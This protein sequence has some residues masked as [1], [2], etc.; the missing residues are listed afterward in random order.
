VTARLDLAACMAVFAAGIVFSQT[1]IFSILTIIDQ[2]GLPLLPADTLILLRWCF[3]TAI[4]IVLLAYAV[5]NVLQSKYRGVSWPKLALLLTTG[6]LYWICGSVSTNL[7]VGVAMFEIFHALQYDTLV[8]SYNRRLAARAGDR[9]GPLR[10]L[11]ASGWLPLVCYIAAIA[12]FGSIKWVAETSDPSTAKVALLTLLFTS[13]T[14]HFYF[15][16]FIWKVSEPGTQQ[17]LGIEGGGKRPSPVRALIHA[18]KWAVVGAAGI[19]LFWVEANHDARSPAEEQSWTALALQ[20][21][22]DVPELLVKNGELLLAAGEPARA[23]E[24][25]RRVVSLRPA[26]PDGNLLLAQ[27]LAETHDIAS[28]RDAAMQAAA[29]DPTSAKRS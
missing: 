20:W 2:V 19:S 22:P 5:N 4:G 25:G 28:A 18:G 6:W 26:S 7:L 21:T 1:R 27:S 12:A 17:N 14:L 11:F 16:G 13:T 24:A 29:L 3:G 9:F 15:D 8:W 10:F 23:T